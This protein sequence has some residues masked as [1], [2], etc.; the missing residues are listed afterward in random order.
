MLCPARARAPEMATHDTMYV[1]FSTCAR[2]CSGAQLVL[3]AR[4]G[5]PCAFGVRLFTHRRCP[6][7]GQLTHSG[8]PPNQGR[9]T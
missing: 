6:N 4:L 9:R 3:T 8:H 2:H 7:P 5:L 1:W